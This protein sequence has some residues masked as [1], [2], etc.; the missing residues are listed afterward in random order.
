[1]KIIFHLL[2]EPASLVSVFI[3]EYPQKGLL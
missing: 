1:M 3:F 2:I